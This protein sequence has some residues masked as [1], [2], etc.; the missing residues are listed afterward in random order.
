MEKSKE[1]YREF[2]ACLE[3]YVSLRKKMKM[4]DQQICL[5]LEE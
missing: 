2:F 5:I 1:K 4:E 3:N